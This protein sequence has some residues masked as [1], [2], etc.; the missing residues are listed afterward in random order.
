MIVP[1]L[2]GLLVT[3]GEPNPPVSVRAET[4]TIQTVVLGIDMPSG[5][6][7]KVSV[8][9]GG[10][11]TVGVV[12]GPTLALM[13]TFLDD[14][15]LALI[16]AELR[17]ELPAGSETL[18][19]LER[20]VLDQRTPTSFSHSVLPLRVE[21]LETG[22]APPATTSQTEAVCTR[23]C[24]V[25]G[26][27]MACACRVQT[28]CGDCCCPD[29]CGCDIEGRRAQPPVELGSPDHSTLKRKG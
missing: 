13:P 9:V 3:F 7:F 23:C 15:R 26:A 21:W 19:E 8:R 28:P 10:R 2:I 12:D 27:E 14:G 1:I 18:Q 16:I 11:A 20:L 22:Q 6:T 24:V 25:C 5:K 29:T 17:V 4:P